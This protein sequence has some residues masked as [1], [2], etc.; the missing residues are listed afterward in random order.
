MKSPYSWKWY[1][2]PADYSQEDERRLVGKLVQI[3]VRA[4][5]ETHF[6]RWGPRIYRQVKGGA[7]GLKAT[8]VVAKVAMEGSETN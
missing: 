7:I 6:Y 4:T 2:S 5:F 3:V 1:R 8:G